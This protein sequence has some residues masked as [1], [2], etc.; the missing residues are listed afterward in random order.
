MFFCSLLFVKTVLGVLLLRTAW[1][2]HDQM[3]E[4]EKE[5]HESTAGLAV[6]L[7]AHSLHKK[8]TDSSVGSHSSRDSENL[9]RKSRSLSEIER[10][11][12]CSNRII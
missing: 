7:D 10:F 3:K 1:K 9:H 2:Y 12:L 5:E 6:G 11:T 8:H 4:S